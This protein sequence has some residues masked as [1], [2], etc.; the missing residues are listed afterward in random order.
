MPIQFILSDNA[1]DVQLMLNCFNEWCSTNGMTVNVS[2][3]NV[4]HFRP[5]SVPKINNDFMC[6]ATKLLIATPHLNAAYALCCS[7]GRIQE[8]YYSFP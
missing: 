5:N 4:V 2:K 1:E 8:I 3:R 6:G 7:L